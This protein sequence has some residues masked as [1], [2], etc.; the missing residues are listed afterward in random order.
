MDREQKEFL[1]RSVMIL[2]DGRNALRDQDEDIYNR[3]SQ[4]AAVLG[5]MKLYWMAG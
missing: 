3:M 4:G 1:Q 5:E 2:N